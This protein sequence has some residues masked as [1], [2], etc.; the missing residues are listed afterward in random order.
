MLINWIPT[1]HGYNGI[2]LKKSLQSNKKIILEKKMRL[3]STDSIS[4]VTE[5]LCHW[6]RKYRSTEEL[7]KECNLITATNKVI[8]WNRNRKTQH[9]LKKINKKYK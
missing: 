7:H 3:D 9:I 6:F 5:Y 4:S 2:F 1:S 8:Y